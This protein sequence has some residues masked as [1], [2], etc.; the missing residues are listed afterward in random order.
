MDPVPRYRFDR[1]VSE[2]LDAL[3]PELDHVLDNVVVQ[4]RER[5]HEEPDLLGLYQGVP[6]TD[7]SGIEGPDI[8]S[9][10]RLALCERVRQLGSVGR[11]G[12][13]HRDPRGGPRRRDRR[14]SAR[15][16]RLGMTRLGRA[17][18]SPTAS[19]RRSSP[20]KI[21]TRRPMSRRDGS[22]GRRSPRTIARIERDE[23]PR[24]VWWPEET[25]RQL[26]AAGIRPARA[27]DLG[28]VHRLL[29]GGWR[30]S[31]AAIWAHCHGLDSASVPGPATAPDLFS[32]GGRGGRRGRSPARLGSS[33][34]G[35]A[36]GR[37]G[38]RRPTASCATPASPP[39][40]SC[41]SGR[42]WV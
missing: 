38:S 11:R 13:R 32:D 8:I 37:D 41:A 26:V 29:V 12:V 10:Y 17:R 24:W 18:R 14:R 4:V 31:P 28:A 42:R 34:T 19:G 5:N 33:V 2:A 3:P 30:N 16:T 23:S 21:P 27:W 9:I 1:M 20:S 6:H 39:S 15:R 25:P 40:A 7:R 36:G 22:T 35:V